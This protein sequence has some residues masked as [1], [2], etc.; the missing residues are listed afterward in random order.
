MKKLRLWAV[1][2]LLAS[3][4]FLAPTQQ[5]KTDSNRPAIDTNGMVR[6]VYF[7]PNDR[8]A[9]PDRM[10]ALQQLIKDAQQF[11]ADEMHRHEFGRKT[12]TVETDNNGEPLVHQINGKFREEYY[13]SEELTD[14]SVWAELIEHFDEDDLQHVYFI[15]IDLSYQA[16]NAGKSGGLGGAIFFLSKGI[17]TLAQPGKLS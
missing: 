10:A 15:A 3:T 4:L 16:L 12:F 2:L 7:L 9:R 11:Y 8:P 14:S 13:Y 17:S 6:L 5:G 1:T